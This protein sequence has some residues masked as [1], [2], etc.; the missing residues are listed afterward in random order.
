MSLGWFQPPF[1]NAYLKKLAVINPFFDLWDVTLLPPKIISLRTWEQ[2][3]CN[4]NI[5]RKIYFLAFQFW[6][7]QGPCL[8]GHLAH[9][10]IIPS[11]INI[12][13]ICFLLD[14]CQLANPDGP[15]LP[16]LNTLQH[17]S[18]STFPHLKSLLPSVLAES[19]SG[20]TGFSLL[21]Q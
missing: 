11:G 12:W 19:T 5:Q 3:L 6:R 13:E 2:S 9:C 18:F 1:K 10:T 21:L 4:E 16:P 8:G 15:T 20:Y 17:L 7:G 14:E